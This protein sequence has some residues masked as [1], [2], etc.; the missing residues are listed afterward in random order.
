MIDNVIKLKVVE[1]FQ[2]PEPSDIKWKNLHIFQYE[3]HKR[4]F[5]GNTI[6]FLMLFFCFLVIFYLAQL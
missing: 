4:N 1:V 5:I 6:V 2:A 3:R